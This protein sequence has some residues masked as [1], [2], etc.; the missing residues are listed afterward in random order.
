M[1]VIPDTAGVRRLGLLGGTFDPIHR[2]HLALADYAAYYAGLDRVWFIPSATPPHKRRSD[3]VDASIRFDMTRAAV[4]PYAPRFAVT[5][6][7]LRRD[8]PSYTVETLRQ[9]R[10]TVEPDTEL[11]WIVGR[12]NLVELPH[13]YEPRRIVEYATIIAGG[14]PGEHV[15]D[16]LPDWFR[17]RLILLDGPAVDVSSTR[18]REQAAK[19]MIDLTDVPE[20]V[21]QIIQSNG[22]YGYTA[23]KNIT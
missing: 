19:G 2:A 17:E 21:V 8:G 1:T 22:L 18:I 13:W 7:E 23:S 16:D 12:D 15:P 20:T 4:E 14:R 10:D 3:L 9:I 6:I 5:D 11:F